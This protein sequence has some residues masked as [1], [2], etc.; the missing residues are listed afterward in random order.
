VVRIGGI[1]SYPLDPV[2]NIR[3]KPGKLGFTDANGVSA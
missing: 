3:L 2:C 1:N